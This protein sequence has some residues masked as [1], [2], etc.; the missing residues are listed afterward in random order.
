ML[1]NSS[2]NKTFSCFLMSTVVTGHVINIAVVLA[3]VNGYS[4]VYRVFD[5]VFLINC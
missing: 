5:S 1:L 4:F 3:F 2:F